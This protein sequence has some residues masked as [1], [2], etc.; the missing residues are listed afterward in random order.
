L[1]P[2]HLKSKREPKVV[3]DE[4]NPVSKFA[5]LYLN[6]LNAKDIV[7]ERTPDE[8]L[9]KVAEKKKLK[10]VTRDMRF[11]LRTLSQHKDIIYEDDSGQWIHLKGKIILTNRKDR[12]YCCRKT[13]QILYSDEIPRP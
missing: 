5:K 7:P 1:S 4:A 3:L 9:L 8:K 10:I 13:M 12:K 11:A 2:L 6:V